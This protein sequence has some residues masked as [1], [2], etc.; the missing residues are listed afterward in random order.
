MLD[1]SHPSRFQ[2]SKTQEPAAQTTPNGFYTGIGKRVFDV[3]LALLLLPALAPVIFVLWCLVRRDGGPGFF[4]HTRIGKGG[5]P[6]KC[7]KIR[8]MVVDAEE[9]LQAYLD[10][11]PDAAAEWERDHKLTI[12]PRINRLGDI[13][14]K[15]SLDE[16]PQIWNV[17][18]GEMSFVGPRPVVAVELIKYGSSASAY[19]AQKPGITGLWQVSG[20]NDISYRER[21]E[22]D[23]AY[24]AARSF[25]KDV[26]IISL[27]AS[28]VFLRTGR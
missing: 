17:L 23:V 19:L 2:G 6:F 10:A 12:D 28:A 21:V 15:T 9:K 18:K 3:S 1:F 20:R 22:M 4:G 25:L 13:L 24:L 26:K 14:R 16:L 5:K 27:T 8:S 11:N 7:W